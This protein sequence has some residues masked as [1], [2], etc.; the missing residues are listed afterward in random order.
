MKMALN[1]RSSTQ[2]FSSLMVDISC[3]FKS[4]PSRN[5]RLWQKSCLYSV[6]GKIRVFIVEALQEISTLI[7]Q[8]GIPI[9]TLKFK[10]SSLVELNVCNWPLGRVA[11]FWYGAKH[12]GGLQSP[13]LSNICTFIIN[14]FIA[15]VV[16]CSIKSCLKYL[17]SVVGSMNW[18]NLSFRL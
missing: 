18:R 14:A 12:F 11:N 1:E 9:Q 3:L 7:N 4:L 17:T 13:L 2:H 16:K 15:K 6:A 10:F 5:G 8:I